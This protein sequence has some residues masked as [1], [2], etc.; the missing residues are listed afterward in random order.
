MAIDSCGPCSVI[1]YWI[2]VYALSIFKS[3]IAAIGGAAGQLLEQNAQALDQ[4]SANFSACKVL[5]ASIYIF[6][7]LIICE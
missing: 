1:S 7:F 6:L 3:L 5:V 4:I 2:L